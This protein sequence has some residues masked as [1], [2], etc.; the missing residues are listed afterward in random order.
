MAGSLANSL[1]PPR[2]FQKSSQHSCCRNRL[3][4]SLQP[5]EPNGSQH[6]TQTPI[7]GLF[8]PSAAKLIYQCNVPIAHNEWQSRS[9]PN[10]PLSQLAKSNASSNLP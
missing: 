9:S 6:L 2:V 7:P 3:P 8:R 5:Y 1:I 10:L 4:G